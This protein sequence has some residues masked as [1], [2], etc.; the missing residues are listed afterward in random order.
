MAGRYLGRWYDEIG[1][2]PDNWHYYDWVRLQEGSTGKRKG[3]V[4]PGRESHKYRVELTQYDMTPEDTEEV[5]CDTKEE[6]IR[7]VNEFLGL[8]TEGQ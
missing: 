5:L 3:V 4:Y 7:I 2:Y 6:A 8:P 1:P